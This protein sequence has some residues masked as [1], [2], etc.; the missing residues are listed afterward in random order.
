MKPFGLSELFRLVW[1]FIDQPGDV[2]AVHESVIH[3]ERKGHPEPTFA[4]NVSDGR[5]WSR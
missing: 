5:D 3:V 4:H 1:D 2:I